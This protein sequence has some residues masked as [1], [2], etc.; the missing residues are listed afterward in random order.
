[1]LDND[2]VQQWKLLSN[3]CQTMHTVCAYTLAFHSLLF[4]LPLSIHTPTM[5]LN[6]CA[7]SSF[8]LSLQCIVITVNDTVT[9][10]PVFAV[11]INVME[12]N[13]TGLNPGELSLC[14]EIHGDED[15]WFNFIS[16]KCLSLNAY[17]KLGQV[18]NR[19]GH[20]I[21]ELGILSED[22]NRLCRQVLAVMND[23]GECSVMVDG[24]EVNVSNSGGLRVN[25][26][27]N[28]IRVSVPNCDNHRVVIWASCEDFFGNQIMR[29][30][31]T[32][33]LNLRPTSHGFLGRKFHRHTH[34]Q[35][36]FTR[37]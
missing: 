20:V 33:G 14:Y 29:L 5:A 37:T 11:P 24:N 12:P 13:P 15:K 34:A 31:V 35:H 36:M 16:D 21:R 25:K 32:R 30:V 23:D 26:N 22:D 8:Y 10:D 18:F 2:D 1:M 27:R 28:R 6:L 7:S 4:S 19:M 9:A 17:Y 3:D